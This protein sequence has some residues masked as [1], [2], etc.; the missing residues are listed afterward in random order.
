MSRSSLAA[1]PNVGAGTGISARPDYMWKTPFDNIASGTG[2]GTGT[3]KAGV[4]ESALTGDTY[5]CRMVALCKNIKQKHHGK[6]SA[7]VL[8]LHDNAP[9]CKSCTSQANRGNVAS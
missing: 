5:A 8:L 6:L 4:Y 1:F 9:A 7:G 3:S 2:A